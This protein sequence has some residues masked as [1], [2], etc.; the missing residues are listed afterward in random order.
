MSDAI[1]DGQGNKREY[2]YD[3]EKDVYSAI[4]ADLK[5]AADL[6]DPA[7]ATGSDR[8][9]LDPVFSTEENASN[10]D[11]WIRFANT[12]RLNVAMQVR[13]IDSTLAETHA[14]EAMASPLISD[15]SGNVVLKY[16]TMADNTE[17]YYYKQAIYNKPNFQNAMYP[18]LGEY[19]YT[20]MHSLGDPRLDA[21]VYQSNAM[22]FNGMTA[23]AGNQFVYNDTITRPHLCYNR[24]N[25]GQG[26]KKCPHY[27]EHNAD[28][29]LKDRL[30]DS[31]SINVTQKYV[32]YGEDP[33]VPGGWQVEIKPGT[34]N[35]FIDPLNT[36]SDYNIS[37][38]RDR[39]VCE[40]AE[41]VLLTY[42]DACFLKAEAEVVFNHNLV[43]A[44]SNYE[45]GIKASMAQYNVAEGDYMSHPGVAWATDMEGV[46]DRRMLWQ[47]KISG[48]NGEEGA[49]EQIYKQRYIADFFN[50]MEGWNL[51]RRTRV[52][53][54]PPYFRKDAST[55][56]IGT[57]PTYNYCN[58]RMNYPNSEM[59]RNAAC[60]AEAVAML[61]AASPYARPERGGDNVFTCLAFAKPVPGIANADEK[62][63]NRR[64]IYFAEYFHNAWG[65]T[66]EE[67]V[68]S[69][70]EYTGTAPSTST[71][72]I[73][74]AL[75]Q[76]AYKWEGTIS[77]FDPT[78]EW[79]P[80]KKDE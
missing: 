65:A 11:K 72:A 73:N 56:V 16:G 75:G 39:F 2:R 14:R 60:Y 24:D 45:E 58:E 17:S 64:M 7:S 20:Y 32:P 22:K 18:A 34:V 1:S 40:S 37:Y 41:M 70:F 47:A 79:T 29:A 78:G 59:S 36:K 80:D 67:L 74:K 66:Y 48:S 6:F 4:L 23:P 53:N 49:L 55:A 27:E 30:R 12:L 10:L 46:H 21:F 76:I 13:T 15:N 8:L 52:N 69:A 3:S 57:N 51:E 33:N 61:Q 26:Y 35:P 44:R 5:D 62:W 38:V 31:I 54:F 63:L 50:G 19:F 28:P 71:S 43:A 42:A 25:A 68:Q 9:D 77:T